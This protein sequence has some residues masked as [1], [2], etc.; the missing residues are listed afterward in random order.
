M[1]VT[2]LGTI[3][4][5]GLNTSTTGTLDTT[6]ATLLVVHVAYLAGNPP[7]ISDSKG[8]GWTGLTE[9]TSTVSGA[10]RIFYAPNPTVGTG[11]TFTFTGTGV[12]CQLVA[13]AFSGIRLTP[14][15][16]DTEAQFVGGPAAT[17]ASPGPIT[18]SV[19]GELVVSGFAW[20]NNNTTATMD[21]G[22][23]VTD[24]TDFVGGTNFGAAFAYKVQ[25]TTTTY[26]PGWTNGA[27][28]RSEAVIA[29]FIP[30]AGVLKSVSDSFTLSDTI[31]E[32][33]GYAFAD[34]LSFSDAVST[35]V[36][37]GG[38]FAVTEL[39][40]DF[41]NIRDTAVATFG[42]FPPGGQRGNIDYDQIRLSARAGTGTKLHTLTGS[43]TT[44]NTV[45][46]DS[47][48]NLIDAGAAPG[49]GTVTHTGGALTNNLPVL[50]AG[51]GDVK[52]GTA[53]QLVPTLPSDAT[54]YLDG[55]GAFTVPA[56]GSTPGLVLLEQHTAS[57]SAALSFTTCITSSY[58]DYLIS[59]VNIIPATNSAIIRLRVS[60]NGGSSY[61]SS[62]IYSVA[63]WLWVPGSQAS[64]GNTAQTY[65][66]ITDSAEPTSN[67]S[68]Y[69]I[70]AKLY[71]Y[72]PLSAV[73]Y[74][75][76]TGEVV[77]FNDSSLVNGI[78]FRGF[79]KSATAVN[80]FQFDFTSGDI[81][82][83]TIRVYGYAK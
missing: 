60:T 66:S 6:G 4:V 78:S 8:N 62:G 79:Y 70:N 34:T 17:T 41:L 1:A 22:F 23:T 27:T 58:D 25:A 36:T 31:G 76:M 15:P 72:N 38:A 5:S 47:S 69:S 52:I 67:S 43:L 20:N 51:S 3:K 33:R 63:Q 2:L 26:S 64:I 12:G 7:A 44:G 9:A 71:L 24:S 77:Q 11:H 40:G 45:V 42:F 29:S 49:T 83:G 59:L 48:G 14:D 57:S 32:G 50:G 74:K 30:E 46:S 56:G 39:L 37:G 16:F 28:G 80:A 13:A 73:T 19:P 68:T 65:F 18:T 10:D 55:T 81:A 75:A 35:T 53:A 21:N 54:K 82:S 61:D